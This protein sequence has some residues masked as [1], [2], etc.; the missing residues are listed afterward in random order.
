MLTLVASPIGNLEDLSFRAVQSL[1][2]C[3]YILCEDTRHSS[4]LLRR[5]DITKPLKSYHKFNQSLRESAI[6][7]DLKEEKEI[8]LLC[9]AGTPGIADPGSQ[10][11]QLCIQEKIQ[12][13]SIPG[14]CAFLTALVCSG[15]D[16][17]RFQFMGFLPKKPSDCKKTLQECLS[18]QG[19][20][21]FYESPKRIANS[22][23]LIATIA[24]KRHVCIA[25]ELTKKFEEF[26]RGTSQEL[27]TYCKDNSLK[28][29]LVL[30]IQGAE[31][32]A[33]DFE[34]LSPLE[35]VQMLESDYQISRKE[36]IKLAA[37][38]RG[39][40]KNKIYN[41]LLSKKDSG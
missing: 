9:D 26:L 2:S 38:L 15:M 21:I 5:Y 4:I 16:T 8:C 17:C 30:L 29:E 28:G 19:T 12:V 35:H 37:E 33:N 22:L 23:S 18:Y 6:L 27:S 36:A 11:V 34:S 7:A 10:L 24:P 40:P 20:S 13:F 14:A 41:R 32:A 39:V 31:K 25:R 1:R 3:D